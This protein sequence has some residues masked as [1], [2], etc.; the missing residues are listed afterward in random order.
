MIENRIEIDAETKAS[1]ESDQ[2][3]P[4]EGIDVNGQRYFPKKHVKSGT[5]GVVWEGRDK[6]NHP[7]AIKFTITDDYKYRS[8]LEEANRA[9]KLRDYPDFF[10][11][12]ETVG[13]VELKLLNNSTRTFVCFVEEWIDGSTVEDYLEQYQVGAFFLKEYAMRMCSA[14]NVLATLKFRHADLH[15]GNVM[16]AKPKPGNLDAPYLTVKVIDTGSLE[17]IDTPLV[18]E[19]QDDQRRFTEHLVAIWNSVHKKKELP[20]NDRR[21]LK[22]AVPLLNSMLEEDKAVG[23]QDPE[24][25]RS[26]FEH[27]W[28]RSQS[29]DEKEEIKLEDPFDYIT[30]EHISSDRL[31]VQMFAESCPWLGLVSNP[32]PILLTGPRGCGKSMVFRRL[33][34]KALLYKSAEDIEQSPIAGFYVSCSADLRNRFGWITT[35]WMAQRF[36]K[37]IVH[38]FNLLLT[39]EVIQTLNAVGQRDDRESLFGFGRGE[40]SNVHSFLMEKLRIT[41]TERLCL[42]GMTPMQHA[43]ELVETEMDKCYGRIIQ[44]TSVEERTDTTFLSDLTRY[45]NR[46]IKYFRERRPTFLVDDFSV[47]R[48]PEPVQAILNPI[49]WDR[50]AT[51]VFKLSSEKYGA[52]IVDMLNGTTEATRE[53]REIDCGQFYLDLG[54]RNLVGAGRQFARELLAKRLELAGY[55][56]TP[57]EILG[58][59]KYGE[60]SLGKALSARAKQRGRKDDQYYGLETIADLCSGDISVLLE[61]YRRIFQEGRVNQQTREQVSGGTQHAAIRAVSSDL[62]N[63]IK[64]YVPRGEEMYNIAYCFG[65]LSRHILR[66]GRLQKKGDSQISCETSRIEVDQVPGQ[67]GEGW[68]EGQRELMLELVR[69]AIFIEMGLGLGRHGFT[70]TLRWQLRR[71]YCPAFGTSL[72]KNTAIK[73]T[74]SEFKYFLTNPKEACSVEFGKRWQTGTE[75]TEGEQLTFPEAGEDTGFPGGKSSLDREEES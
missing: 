44:G 37:A 32:D 75:N 65:N 50:Q 1:L 28:T 51:H 70:P 63:L 42:Q 47:H 11:R 8:P 74:P 5:K 36:R 68:T 61:I 6:Y 48:I 17:P 31:L 33:S 57:E 73:W 23:L 58:N 35:E 7:V 67:P 59:S 71:V 2:V 15:M 72:A 38:Y 69:R 24:K 29:P 10:A 66:E 52:A 27:V 18:R 20:L 9:V 25:I 26:Q 45:L 22:E 53:L 12:F 14:L 21:F 19:G 60:G 13:M 55:D 56:G 30:A 4:L 39:R 41:Q 3:V 54:D 64:S 49:I 43:F 16:I 40:E 34:L 46:E 62:L